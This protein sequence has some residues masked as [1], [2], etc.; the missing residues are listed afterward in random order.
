M[1]F[2]FQ[3]HRR[4]VRECRWAVRPKPA[5]DRDV[6][7]KQGETHCHPDAGMENLGTPV[8]SMIQTQASGR[9]VDCEPAW[10][11]SVVVPELH[12]E[13]GCSQSLGRGKPNKIGFLERSGE[14]GK[15]RNSALTVP[16]PG[17]RQQRKDLHFFLS[18]SSIF[19]PPPFRPDVL[20]PP[21]QPGARPHRTYPPEHSPP[22]C[23]NY[24]RSLSPDRPRYHRE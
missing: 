3:V 10:R 15:D 14:D 1:S 16:R 20:K 7:R 13:S 6:E 2:P 12:H 4:F 9:V 22:A 23:S 24:R 11:S 17:G 5:R 19:A 18:L 21:H 8:M